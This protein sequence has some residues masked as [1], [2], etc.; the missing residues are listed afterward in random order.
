MLGY[1]IEGSVTVTEHLLSIIIIVAT[2]ILAVLTPFI[3][4]PA[5]DTDRIGTS[6]GE[7]RQGIAEVATAVTVVSAVRCATAI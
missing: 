5:R 2:V 6:A 1:C 4:A 7:R 3:A